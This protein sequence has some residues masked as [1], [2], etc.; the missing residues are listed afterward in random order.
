MRLPRLLVRTDKGLLRLYYENNKKLYVYRPR[1]PNCNGCYRSHKHS[2]QRCG[3]NNPKYVGIYELNVIMTINIDGSVDKTDNQG[4][5]KKYIH[6]DGTKY[7]IGRL[8]TTKG[9]HLSCASLNHV[10]G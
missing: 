10:D 6:I 5:W 8:S 3:A 9:R 2:N 7:V 1:N 4:M